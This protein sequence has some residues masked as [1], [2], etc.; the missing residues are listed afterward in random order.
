MSIALLGVSEGQGKSFMMALGLTM[1]K[2]KMKFP[3]L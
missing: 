1:T 3:S 2:M